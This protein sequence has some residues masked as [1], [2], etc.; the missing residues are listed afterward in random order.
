MPTPRYRII[1]TLTQPTYEAFARLAE[2]QGRSKGSAVAEIMETLTPSL[3][4][5]IALLEAAQEAHPSMLAKLQQGIEGM[6]IEL[7][8]SVGQASRGL[9]EIR[10]SARVIAGATV[11]SAADPARGLASRSRKAPPSS[12]TGGNTTKARK[13]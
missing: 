2:L 9:E 11:G 13:P 6:E 7:F 12:N 10:Q 1:T 8:R 3:T 5:T 4:R